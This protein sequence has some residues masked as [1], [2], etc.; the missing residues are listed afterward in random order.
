[1]DIEQQ[2]ISQFAFWAVPAM[3]VLVVLG[4]RGRLSPHTLSSVRPRQTGLTGWDLLAALG[5]VI[6]GVFLGGLV[7]AAAGLNLNKP[8]AAWTATDA[9]TVA[10]NS[11]LMFGLPAGYFL[12]RTAPGG[13]GPGWLAAGVVPRRPRRELAVG[14]LGLLVA[15]PLVMAINTLGALIAFY[16]GYDVSELGHGMLQVLQ[17]NPDP[18]VVIL[19][20]I[21]AIILAPVLEEVVFRGL[22]QSVALRW[23]GPNHRWLAIFVAAGLFAVV[24]LGATPWYVLPGLF[25]LAVIL[26][27]LYERTG[28]LLPAIT[29]HFGFNALNVAF[30]MLVPMQ[31]P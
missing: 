3:I 18:A 19:V 25:S 22:L 12:G 9:A 15:V 8:G 14:L 21:T 17:Q 28:S 7:A 6:V 5:L 20:A 10:I 31:T 30:V 29:L 26:G 11:L 2:L 1:M 24:H 13:G 4:L 27:Y 16:Q 23:T